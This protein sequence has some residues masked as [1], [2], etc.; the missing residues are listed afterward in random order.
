MP[1][2]FTHYYA[3]TLQSRCRAVNA[4]SVADARRCI[5]SA[6]ETCAAW[7]A[8]S[9]GFIGPDTRLVVLPEYF[10]TGFPMGDP[11]QSWA[12]KAGIDVDGPEH[13]A[14]GK[15]CQDNDIFLSGYRDPADRILVATAVV[16]DLTLMT[17]DDRI[18]AYPHL[19]SSDARA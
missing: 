16:H 17:A 9:K 3:L 15:I 4:L 7:I 6:I 19:L 14:L 1:V 8:A 2:L 10:L 12:E 5:D 11:V 18:L 13:E